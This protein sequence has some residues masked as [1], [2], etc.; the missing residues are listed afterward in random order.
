HVRAA[1]APAANMFVPRG[2]AKIHRAICRGQCFTGCDRV[3]EDIVQPRK[4]SGRVSRWTERA[5]E[6]AAAVVGSG[7]SDARA[8]IAFLPAPSQWVAIGIAAGGC[9]DKWSAFRNGKIW[10]GAD[11]GRVICQ[12]CDGSA[13]AASARSDE[14]FDLIK[15][16]GMEVR[17][18]V[19]LQI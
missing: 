10:A 6:G 12:G 8:K 17:I 1:D 11:R 3:V 16:R 7:Q 5:K 15:A 2:D 4:C 9:Q 18:T 13:C 19:R 14:C